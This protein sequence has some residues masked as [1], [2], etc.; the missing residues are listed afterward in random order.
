MRNKIVSNISQQIADI[1]IEMDV[2][3][4]IHFYI[5]IGY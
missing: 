1:N 5:Y 4:N 3:K 2:F